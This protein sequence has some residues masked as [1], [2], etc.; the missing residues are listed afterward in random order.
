MGETVWSHDSLADDLARHLRCEKTMVW[1]DIQLGP[2]GSPRPD[3]YTID[4]SYAHPTPRA[5]EVKVSAADFR[6][7]V[8]AGKWRSYL[9]YAC[10]VT[11]AV[12]AGLVA[13]Q[14]LPP[15]TGLIVR[16][17][18][19]W[20]TLRRATP[21]VVEIP[22][23]A[24]LKLLIDGI[25]REGGRHRA[26]TYSEA[27][28]GVDRFCKKFGADAALWVRRREAAEDSVRSAE[29]AA[30]RI[31][32][33]AQYRAEQI[34]KEATEEAPKQW[35]ALIE[36]LGLP[37][38]STVWTVRDAVRRVSDSANG[39]AQPLALK[40]LR[41]DLEN[42]LRHVDE[43]SLACGPGTPPALASD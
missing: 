9:A 11:F 6:A 37:E 34:R 14:D 39:W 27:R 16:G 28:D 4:K 25:E 7:D 20:R 23:V 26:R 5:Y 18:T 12:P 15:L 36:A 22:E 38:E 41:R 30:E 13:T 42:A 32:S 1:T 40:S 33:E 17:E 8:T 24:L 31:T 35:R 21:G 29:Y 43:L 2:S 3:V 10:A 19:G